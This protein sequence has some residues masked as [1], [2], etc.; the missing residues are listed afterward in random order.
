MEVMTEEDEE[1]KVDAVE[2]CGASLSHDLTVPRLLT[3]S[4]MMRQCQHT[5]STDSR[6][7]DSTAVCKNWQLHPHLLLLELPIREN[8]LYES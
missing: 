5:V 4:V 1:A 7:A 3:I 8:L 2:Y 6:K